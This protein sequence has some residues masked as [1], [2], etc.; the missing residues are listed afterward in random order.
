MNLNRRKWRA[1]FLWTVG[2]VFLIPTLLVALY[3]P[4]F[5]FGV[6]FFLA[7][8][9]YYFPL[10]SWIGEPFFVHEPEVIFRVTIFGR[11]LTAI[12]YTGIIILANIFIDWL[13]RKR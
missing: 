2:G 10:A 9:L 3:Q 12:I 7:H 5:G 6:F 4:N 1:I 8:Q 13:R 11:L